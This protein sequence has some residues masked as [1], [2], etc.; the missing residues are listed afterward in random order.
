MESNENPKNVKKSG[1]LRVQLQA[2][3]VISM[4]LKHIGL[5]CVVGVILSGKM[6]EVLLKLLP[7]N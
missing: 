5:L 4:G 6:M 7:L 1:H 2:L 3:C